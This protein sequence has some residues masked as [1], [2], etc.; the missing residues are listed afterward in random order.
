MLKK[1]GEEASRKVN[2]KTGLAVGAGVI[3]AAGLAVISYKLLRSRRDGAGAA[4]SPS[5]DESPEKS[6]QSDIGTPV[7]NGGGVQTGK[8]ETPKVW[9]LSWSVPSR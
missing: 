5:N 7:K 3:A 6:S 4:P 9:R 1:M 8:Q 2:W